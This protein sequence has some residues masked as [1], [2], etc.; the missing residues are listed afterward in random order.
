[1]ARLVYSLKIQLVIPLEHSTRDY[2][3]MF[4]KKPQQQLFYEINA[5]CD[6]PDD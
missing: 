3:V 6:K 4:Y 5:R 1:M 2:E